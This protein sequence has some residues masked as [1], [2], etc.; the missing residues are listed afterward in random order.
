MS[1]VKKYRLPWT[2]RF[3][4]CWAA[5]VCLAGGAACAGW[6]ATGH[7]W[8][9]VVHT[10]DAPKKFYK[11]IDTSDPKILRIS[12]DDARTILAEFDLDPM[13]DPTLP[14]SVSIDP[15]KLAAPATELYKLGPIQ[16]VKDGDPF[17]EGTH[18]TSP[19]HPDYSVQQA[20]TLEKVDRTKKT[21][22]QIRIY[23]EKSANP[24]PPYDD[25]RGCLHIMLN[26]SEGKIIK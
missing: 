2:D 7:V 13:T 26:T 22:I 6:S 11:N 18:G 9:R 3:V 16:A 25:I 23:P 15:I 14:E 19:K 10:L 8:P 20:F 4:F 12:R 17:S 1:T 5:R 21:T 24:K